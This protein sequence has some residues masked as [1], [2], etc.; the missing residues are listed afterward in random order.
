MHTS[1]KYGY[2][3]LAL[4]A[5]MVFGFACW[6]ASNWSDSTVH[7][8]AVRASRTALDEAA[9]R[10]EADPSNLNARLLN[11]AR[12]VFASAVAA[13]PSYAKANPNPTVAPS[14]MVQLQAL[15][16]LKGSL[17]NVEKKIGSRLLIVLAKRTG[18][19]PVVLDSLRTSVETAKVGDN[20]V[21]DITVTNRIAGLKALDHYNFVIRSALGKT[22]RAEVP[23]NKLE[24][25]AGLTQVISIREP[26]KRY[27]S[28]FGPFNP[29]SSLPL[30]AGFSDRAERVGG[31]LLAAMSTL[32]A[33]RAAALPFVTNVSEGDKT[34]R[35]IDGRHT[36]G[37]NGA[38]IK[39]GVISDGIDSL[40]SLE[41]SGDL[42]P[43]VT[44]LPGQAG[45][46]DEGCAMLEIVHDLAPGAQLFFA[47]A[48][49]DQAQFAQN[50]RDLRT[51]GC[52]II[53]DDVI[54]L[55]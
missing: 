8:A 40:S 23:F 17:T 37:V 44:V 55:D 32:S 19:L 50:I 52:D 35:A 11:E 38:G 10:Y 42:P 39:V 28:S 34:H 14:A 46:G 51:A 36:F 9:L 41:A 27:T 22:I 16:G 5:L 2:R 12:T 13:D 30:M 45:S 26:A 20:A 49:P 48:D 25:I 53:V 1:R 4:L 6:Q 43:V 21:V 24:E 7:A 54:Y 33:P 31:K 29:A 18:R 15:R 3:G 47:T